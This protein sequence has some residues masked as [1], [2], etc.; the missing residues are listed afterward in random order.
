MSEFNADN[1]AQYI[2]SS[3][4]DVALWKHY[5][6]SG[7]TA[8]TL[9]EDVQNEFCKLNQKDSKAAIKAMDDFATG[10]GFLKVVSGG[11][12]KPVGATYTSFSYSSQ[13]YMSFD[14]PYSD[15]K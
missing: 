4:A 3:M 12:S 7:E 9:L 8:N 11:D 6:P 2:A 15:K 13:T 5:E 1:E 10:E 14:C